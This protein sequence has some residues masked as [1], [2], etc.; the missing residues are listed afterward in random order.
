MRLGA[1]VSSLTLY[2]RSHSWPSVMK[3]WTLSY[4]SHGFKCVSAVCRARVCVCVYV[5]TTTLTHIHSLGRA[6]NSCP[7]VYKSVAQ[8]TPFIVLT[9][10]IAH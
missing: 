10:C 4:P 6:P 7:P 9:L 1:C 2:S 8:L 5:D 3:Q